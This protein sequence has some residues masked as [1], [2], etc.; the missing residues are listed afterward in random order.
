MQRMIVVEHDY[1]DELNEAL[2]DGWKV[3]MMH[4]TSKSLHQTGA[5][6]CYVVIEKD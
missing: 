3:V 1:T 4:A 2:A 6:F 5:S